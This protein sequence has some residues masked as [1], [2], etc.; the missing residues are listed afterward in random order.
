VSRRT[1]GARTGRGLSEAGSR[2]RAKRLIAGGVRAAVAPTLD[3]ILADERWMRIALAEGARGLGRTT[4]NPAVGCVLVGG[5][6]E[7]ARGFY[8]GSGPHAE[9][10]ALKKAGRRAGGATAYVTL[11]PHAHQG[12]TPPCTDALIAAGVARVVVGSVDP[13][14][15]V[16]GR[17]LRQLKDAGIEVV[18]GVLERDCD[19]LIRGYRRFITGRGPLVHLKMAATLD[20]RIAAASGDARW[21]SGEESRGLVQHMRARAEAILVGIGT[22]LAD[23]PR[24]TCRIPGAP[25]PLRVVL[26]PELRTPPASKVVKGRGKVL[27]VGSPKA[28][29]ARR[30][31]LEAA[32]AEVASFDSRGARGWKR[33]LDLLAGRGVMELLVEGGASVAASAVRAGVVGRVSIFYNP[34]FMGG[35][36]VPMMH[37]LGVKRPGDGPKLS[38][39]AIR[40]IGDD[41][42]WEGEPALHAKGEPALHAKV[43]RALRSKGEPALRS[44][45]KS[46]LD[47]KGERAVRATPRT[48]RPR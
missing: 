15:L 7:I 16:A 4:P 23:D 43:E 12:R 31:R 36:A 42:L 44:K 11:E 19:D 22:V 38:T 6:R 10:V 33:L 28:A 39:L 9:A 20:G 45:R 40:P 35:D 3:E 17:G 29:A 8:A 24:L 13:N 34:R 2:S 1:S 47:E 48:K 27:I 5:D 37:S 14:A 26:D 25:Q 32:G 41:F 21:I 18:L 46:A 30:R